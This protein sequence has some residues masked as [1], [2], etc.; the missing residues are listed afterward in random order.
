[1]GV[2]IVPVVLASL[3]QIIAFRVVLGPGLDLRRLDS[4]TLLAATLLMDVPWALGVLVLARRWLGSGPRELGLVRPPRAALRFAIFAGVGTFVATLPLE[5]IQRSAFGGQ[6][7]GIVEA[8]EAHRGAVAFVFDVAAGV[9][10]API[11]EELAFRGVLF[12]GLRQRWSF[13]PSAAVSA[14][15]FAAVHGTDVLLPIF[16][17]GLVL[18]LVYERTRSLLACMA[19]HATVNLIP[20]LI[21]FLTRS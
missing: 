1:V 4:Q 16:V 9:V 2:L 18:A 7:Q 20:L 14:A 21:L 3:L 8:L 15:A 11:A 13:L 5:L 17:A 6:Q 10:L 12:A 19:T